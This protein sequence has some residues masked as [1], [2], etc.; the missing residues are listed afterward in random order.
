MRAK[1]KT[2]SP[3]YGIFAPTAPRS[4]IPNAPLL[5]D[6]DDVTRLLDC[7]LKK[8]MNFSRRFSKFLPSRWSNFMASAVEMEGVKL[9]WSLHSSSLKI[10]TVGKS[11]LDYHLLF[12]T[13]CVGIRNFENSLILLN[14]VLD[15]FKDNSL[16]VC[17]AVMKK[18]TSYVGIAG[19]HIK[20][21]F[22]Y[23]DCW[24]IY[25]CIF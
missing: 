10:V 24:I 16:T 11:Y 8:I 18:C 9:I 19:A 2:N 13:G 20:L 25:I 21:K 15:E 14:C 12:E 7:A 4:Y 17:A 6:A 22:N 3:G 23:F 1:L 5:R